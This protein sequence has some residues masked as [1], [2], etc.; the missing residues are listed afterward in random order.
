VT[1]L[2]AHE[3]DKIHFYDVSYDVEVLTEWCD[4]PVPAP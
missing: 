4:H 2:G 1:A 3:L